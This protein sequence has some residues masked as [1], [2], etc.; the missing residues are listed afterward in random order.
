[1]KYFYLFSLCK[2]IR[3]IEK[4]ACKTQQYPYSLKKRRIYFYRSKLMVYI[5]YFY[6]TSLVLYETDQE[7]IKHSRITV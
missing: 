4:H 5:G 2:I 3:I 1:M 6:N 7:N